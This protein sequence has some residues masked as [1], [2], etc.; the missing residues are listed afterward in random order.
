MRGSGFR[1]SN[2]NRL[3]GLVSSSLD[4]L[5]LRHKVL[6]HQALERWPQVV[7][8][9]IAASTVAT[10]VRDGVIFVACKSSMW[11]NELTFHKTNIINKLNKSVGKPVIID[12]RFS[13]RGFR[14]AVESRKEE[15]S[16][17]AKGLES[18]PVDEKDVE[19]AERI[20]AASG[21]SELAERIRR[22]VLT[23]KRLE[24]VKRQEGWHECVKC[25][26]LH[27]DAGD[28]CEDCR[29]AST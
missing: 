11:C 4:N 20:A 21:S 24:A 10:S 7:G 16:T 6:E 3:G 27:K 28:L 25:R 13:A 9:Q 14:K 2:M 12:I 8:P 15:A 1:R 5:G 29:R 22:A 17:K 19:T 18:V 23:S 26:S